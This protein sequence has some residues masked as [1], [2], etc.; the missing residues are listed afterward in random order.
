MDFV[1]VV[2][3]LIIL[4]FGCCTGNSDLRGINQLFFRISA[5]SLC[6]NR[7]NIIRSLCR[8]QTFKNLICQNFIFGPAERI[9]VVFLRHIFCRSECVKSKIRENTPSSIEVGFIVMYRMCGITQIFQYI[10]RTFTSRFF[11]DTLIRILTRSEIMQT[12]TGD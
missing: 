1:T 11:Q 9:L 5:M 2:F 4:C 8:I 10:R 12:H 3:P 7:I 6:G